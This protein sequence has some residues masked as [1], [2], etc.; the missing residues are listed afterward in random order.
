MNLKTVK[1]PYGDINGIDISHNSKSGNARRYDVPAGYDGLH[2]I[3]KGA[4]QTF[5]R[6]PYNSIIA[7]H[8]VGILRISDMSVEEGVSTAVFCGAHSANAPARRAMEFHADS[9]ELGLA[10]QGRW[11]L[12]V[13]QCDIRLNGVDGKGWENG[14]HFMYPHQVG[15]KGVSWKFVKVQGANTEIAKGTGRPRR[16]FYKDPSEAPAHHADEDGY[17]PVSD[18]FNEGPTYEFEDCELL[19]FGTG[20]YGGGGVVMQ[21]MG[22]HLRMRRCLVTQSPNVTTGRGGTVMV[23]DSGRHEHF[24]QDPDDPDKWAASEPPAVQSVDISECIFSAQD[25]PAWLS[26]MFRVGTL[27]QG[28]TEEVL[29]KLRVSASG[30]YGSNRT[31]AISACPDAVLENLN[32]PS[33]T[34]YAKQLGI[35]TSG[36]PLIHPWMQK[37]RP[38]AQGFSGSTMP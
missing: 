20:G 35:D 38:I 37:L 30:F 19:D 5:I 3:G 29:R 2:L 9:C 25:G 10:N 1:L 31:L 6:G 32:H 36:S 28:N 18:S 27:T 33:V 23:D 11:V 16:M 13:N 26:P 12:F 34:E 7:T 8:D 24:G 4:G 21:G 17:W 15:T 14:E 22:G